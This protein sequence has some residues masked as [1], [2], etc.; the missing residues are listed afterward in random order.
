M[1]DLRDVTDLS[2]LDGR[3][4]EVEGGVGRI[5]VI[6]PAGL[7]ATVNADVD[8]PGDVVL[9]GEENGGIG[10]S[11]NDY[12]GFDNDPEIIINAQPGCR[13][14]R[15]APMSTT[16]TTTERPS[17]RHP[18]NVGHLVMGIAFLG[19]VGVWALIQGDVVGDG[20]VRWL[21]PVPWVLAGL[22]GLL[23]IGVSGS[24]R[25]STRQVGWV[26]TDAPSPPPSR[27]HRA[28]PTPRSWRPRPTRRTDERHHQQAPDPPPRRPDGRRRLLRRRRLP[29]ARP[30]PGPAARVVAA[31]FSVGTVAVAYIAAWILMPE[32]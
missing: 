31:I 24:K 2:S 19:L 25:W 26:G 13:T 23:A 29:R 32:V 9:F 22:A 30:D 5:E 16:T 4:L 11:E 17:G 20:D 3:T 7:A 14:D 6:L 10:V 15:G 28:P 21:L 18:V 1:I 12:D 8:G 27:H